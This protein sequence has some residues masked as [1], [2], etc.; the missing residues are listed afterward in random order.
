[1]SKMD[2][3]FTSINA[4]LVNAKFNFNV[5]KKI[6]QI[7]VDQLDEIVIGKVYEHHFE[8]TITRRLN[9]LPMDQVLAEATFNVRINTENTET[10]NSIT[11]K[12]KVG[13]PMLGNVFSRV[14]L[15]ISQI[16]SQGPYGPIITVPAYDS[17]KIAIRID[18]EE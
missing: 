11:D 15:V 3:N 13:M 14:S 6:N 2:S 7:S 10:V 9:L 1:M 16:T 18:R 5:A 12:V 8:L 17:N 4:T